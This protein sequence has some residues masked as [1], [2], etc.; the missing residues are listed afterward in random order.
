MGASPSDAGVA[1][2]AI[3]IEPPSVNE[4]SAQW[5]ASPPIAPTTVM[6]VHR[7]LVREVSKPLV[8]VVALLVGIFMAYSLTR[9][10]ADANEGVL[11][12]SAVSTLTGLKVLIALEV[13]IPIALYVGMI[14]A[15]GRFYSDHEVTALKAGGVGEGRIVAPV[16]WLSLTVAAVV[17]ALS[18][19]V[20]P[21]AYQQLYDFRTE[22]EASADLEEITPGRFHLHGDADRMVF[23]EERDAE[24]GEFAGL[25][26]RSRKASDLEVISGQRGRIEIFAK[27]GAH[28]LNLDNAFVYR[29]TPNDR[30]L[31]GRFDTFSIWIPTLIPEPVGH[32][33]KAISTASLF[34]SDKAA[35]RAE[36]Q[37]RLSTSV[38]TVLL[39]LLAV[40]LGRARPRGGRYGRILLATA[41]YAIYFN[42]IG[43]ARSGVEQG[44]LDHL[45]WVPMGLATV[46]V[47]TLLTPQR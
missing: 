22:A 30:D 11:S 42:F 14:V 12:A 39:A 45:W 5:M 47:A 35:D 19:V 33:S 1:V 25:F 44:T 21:W 36:L 3:E 43:I 29:Q 40:P 24:T 26:V 37:W 17:G 23:L 28:R 38:S 46:V 32:R 4:S 6:I 16:V 15:L 7:Y 13:L 27:P 41:A 20:R 2:A 9:F 18:I 8:A 34:D 10:L 31:I